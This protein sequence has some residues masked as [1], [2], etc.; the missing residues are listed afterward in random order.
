MVVNDPSRLMVADRQLADLIAWREDLPERMQTT[1]GLRGVP[2]ELAP[3]AHATRSPVETALVR[4]ELLAS[5]GESLEELAYEWGFDPAS[6]GGDRRLAALLYLRRRLE[7]ASHHFPMQ[8]PLRLIHAAHAATIDHRPSGHNRICPAHP[9]TMTL[10]VESPSGDLY[11]TECARNLTLAEVDALGLL[12][13]VNANPVVPIRL[14]AEMLD[15]EP[16][17][18]RQWV[19]RGHLEGIAGMV[20]LGE[21]YDCARRDTPGKPAN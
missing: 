13:L 15:L 8:E 9:E 16:A 21:V 4:A 12:H 3:A 5:I 18:I 20:Y 19:R 11:C 1:L 6:V 17:T 10:L 7:W 14:A 2:A